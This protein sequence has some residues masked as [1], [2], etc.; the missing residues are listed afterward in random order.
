MYAY[1]MVQI[2][3]QICRNIL[4]RE[5]REEY[6][7]F[8]SAENIINNLG[9]KTFYNHDE[10]PSVLI[11]QADVAK[12]CLLASSKFGRDIKYKELLPN[13]KKLIEMPIEQAGVQRHDVNTF[14]DAIPVITAHRKNSTYYKLVDEKEK[15][16]KEQHDLMFKQFEDERNRKIELF[17]KRGNL[18]IDFEFKKIVSIDFEFNASKKGLEAATEFGIS[19]YKNGKIENLHFLIEENYKNKGNRDLQK[20]FKFGTTQYILKKD[21]AKKMNEIFKDTDYFLFHELSGDNKILKEIGINLE[22]RPN[23]EL[24]DTQ[25]F[26]QTHFRDKE[27]EIKSPTLK[28]LLEAF[29]IPSQNLH[30]SGNDAAYTLKLF[31]GMLDEYRDRKVLTPDEPVKK[32]IQKFKIS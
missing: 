4:N 9:V 25:I 2:K 17:K 31:Q 30:N 26:F 6:S 14:Q 22:Q 27:S 32:N 5:K 10:Q 24:I 8:F 19:I 3:D 13:I 28:G 12:V 18:D 20:K 23:C 21:V 7:D 16:K 29:N 1:S 11:S 15:L